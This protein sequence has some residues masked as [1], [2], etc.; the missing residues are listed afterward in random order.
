[1][2]GVHNSSFLQYILNFII[3]FDNNNNNNN[4]K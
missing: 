1:M 2:I 4:N 3:M